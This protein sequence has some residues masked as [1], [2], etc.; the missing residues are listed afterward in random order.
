MTL[1]QLRYLLAVVDSGLNITQASQRLFT[2]QPGISRQLIQLEAELGVE[3]FARRGKSLASLTP[4]GLQV[5]ERARRIWS[6]AENI[7]SIASDMSER[8]EGAISIA[9]THTQARYV[10]PQVIQAFRKR[11]PKVS[12]ELHQGTAEQ[13]SELVAADVVDLAIATGARGLFPT[14]ALLPAYHWDRIVLVP[15]DHELALLD[16]A[17]DIAE[18]A[19]HPLVTYVF[20]LTGEASFRRA[21]D[22]QGLEPDVVFTAR[23][24]D[25]IKT[26]VRMGMG[27]G[28]IAAMAFECSDADSLAALDAR[29][30]F[31]RCTTWLGFQRG[32]RLRRYLVDF[33]SLFAPHLTQP[34]IDSATSCK[35]QAGVD[36][37]FDELSLP[38][39]GGCT[40]LEPAA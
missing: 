40:E 27:I 26:H 23:D 16:R 10:L 1:Q 34:L 8:R 39:K 11:Y 21:F 38:V 3:L 30:L 37:L 17:P 29:A 9:T 7:R 22:E 19:R 28:V 2:S 14:L 18:L 35:D 32:K 13:I 6:E 33:A 31:P 4:A 20:S 15:R 24:A 5:V 25:V 12:V 36:S